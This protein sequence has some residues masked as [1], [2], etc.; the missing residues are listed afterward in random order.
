MRTASINAIFLCQR[1]GPA[2]SAE[3]KLYASLQ[4]AGCRR[5]RINQHICKRFAIIGV[6]LIGGSIA[7]AI[8]KR[9]PDA[10][11]I[12]IGRTLSRLEAA[13]AA[14]LL[15]EWATDIAEQPDV[16][17]VIAATPVS[18]LA[19]DLRHAADT[20]ASDAVF[21]DAGS[22]KEPLCR[23]LRDIASFVGAHPLAG[24]EQVGW[25]HADADLFEDR[26]CVITPG[27][28][29]SEDATHRVTRF[30]A[31]IGMKTVT[32][33][34]A[35]HDRIVAETSHIPHIAAAAVVRQLA[36]VSETFVASG[37]RDTTRVAAGDA[38]M[39]TAIAEANADAI[40]RQLDIVERDVAQLRSAIA[41][42]EWLAVREWFS[43]AAT[44]RSRLSFDETPS[45]SDSNVRS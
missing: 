44:K 32:L 40:C 5:I 42:G 39:W 24:S 28:H 8:R 16:D 29:S 21:T 36:E 27:S 14:G 11:V 34:A 25:E 26:T 33:D 12:G 31:M 17:V 15:D 2:G 45:P 30:W 18:R 41:A 1:R 13:G 10:R 6:G 43:E 38:V 3:H 7:A 22:V 19:S 9:V 23:A 20:C 35:E 37:F 4:L